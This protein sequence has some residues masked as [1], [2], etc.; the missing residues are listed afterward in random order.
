MKKWKAEWKQAFE[1]PAPIRKGDFLRQLDLP[2]ISVQQ[3]LFSQIGYIRK[4]VWYV[5]VLIFSVSLLGFAFL[6]DRVLWLISGL[7]P[8]LALTILSESG[9][10]ELY[11][12][13]ELEM[14]TRFSLRSVTLARLGIL[15]VAN[16][17][18]LGLLL[19]MGVWNDTR[20]PLAAVIYILTPFLLTTFTGL[21]IVRKCKGQEGMYAC[22]GT[23]VGI[24]LSLF[25]S[26]NTL[27]CLYQERW[28]A[29]WMTAA[30]VLLFGNGKQ[31]FALIKRTEELAWN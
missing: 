4:W 29:L 10:S 17:L 18:F 21:H 1:A 22:V 6:P 2:P 20:N 14:A 15:G 24:S 8:I 28:L 26:H 12:M 9:R 11:G 3:F 30:M 23:A 5:S 27:P 25:L 7:T 16:L 31:C 13:A 19:P